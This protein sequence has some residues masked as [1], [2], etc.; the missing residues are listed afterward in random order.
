V[1]LQASEGLQDRLESHE[2]DEQGHVVRRFVL[3]PGMRLGF[4]VRIE[5]NRLTMVLTYTEC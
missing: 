4:V 2:L 1:H 5:E 3:H